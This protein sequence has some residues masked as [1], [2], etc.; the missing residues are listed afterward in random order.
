MHP[1][2]WELSGVTPD[3]IEAQRQSYLRRHFE[4]VVA[5]TNDPSSPVRLAQHGSLPQTGD[6]CFG[7]ELDIPTVRYTDDELSGLA[8]ERNIGALLRLGA[9]KIHDSMVGLD[10]GP[11]HVA[12]RLPDHPDQRPEVV[13][14]GLSATI[15][16]PHTIGHN[17]CIVD[18]WRRDM[19]VR[20][21]LENLADCL[22]FTPGTY[23]LAPRNALNPAASEFF[24]RQHKFELPLANLARR[25]VA[26]R[27]PGLRVLHREVD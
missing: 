14:V 1:R 26:P 19:T 11:V 13:M 5:A 17:I 24:A 8:R 6:Q 3:N 22:V 2:C 15:A 20:Q 10:A 16:H 23:S 7:V 9:A 18:Q 4:S 12:V 21:L 25:P 27:A